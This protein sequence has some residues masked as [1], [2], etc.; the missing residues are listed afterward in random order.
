MRMAINIIYV[1]L[2]TLCPSLEK[3]DLCDVLVHRPGKYI[4]EFSGHSTDLWARVYSEF[5]NYY[6]N[7]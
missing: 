7:I 4:V 3:V 2:R 5:K 1:H 6:G